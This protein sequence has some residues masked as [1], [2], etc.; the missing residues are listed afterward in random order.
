MMEIRTAAADPE[1]RLK[2]IVANQKNREWNLVGRVPNELAGF[3]GEKKLLTLSNRGR[4]PL[5]PSI[6]LGI[7]CI[8]LGGKGGAFALRESEN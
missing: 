5:R 6:R 4:K 1:K 3:V 8:V 7:L 2:A